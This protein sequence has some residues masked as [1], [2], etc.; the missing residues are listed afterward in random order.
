MGVIEDLRSARQ[1]YERREWVAAYRSL[2][3]LDETDLEAQDFA[4]LATTAYLLGRRNDCIQALQRAHQASLDAGDR[5][6]AVRAAYSL[7]LTLRNVGEVAVSNGWLARATRLL[8]ELT[9]DVVERGYLLDLEMMGHVFSG[10]FAEA[11]PLA[12]RIAEYGRRFGEPD[13]VALGLHAEGR[14]MLYAGRVADGLRR[15]DEALVGVMAGEVTPVTAGRVYCSTIEACQE[16]SD[17]GRAGEWTH[18]LTTWCDVQPGLVA[19]TGQCATHRGQLLRLHG[20]YAD[21]VEELERA[22]ERYLALGGH[23]AQALAHYERGETH[24]LRGDDAEA[25]AAF[26]SAAEHGHPA[27]PGRALL[28]LAH[29]RREAAKG[30]VLR[31][32]AER[33][34]PVQRSQ[35]LAAA[36]E[37]LLADGDTDD[38]AAL[39]QE[40]LGIAETFGCTGLQA[41]GH[42]T[43]AMVAL[44]QDAPAAALEAARRAMEAWAQLSAPYEVARSRVLIGRALRALGD[45]DSAVAEL[46]AARRTFADLGAVPAEKAAAA[47]LGDERAPGG[48]TPREVEVL[49]LVAVGK[50]N[51]AIATQLF[52]SE[53]TVARH[54]SNIFLKLDVGSRTAAAAFAY[55]NHLV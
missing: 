24:R 51:A 32:L 9:D 7:V 12:P 46:T 52:L 30:A 50:S 42:C 48:L 3:D 55:E 19:Y 14:M 1:T 49:R 35:V 6:G 41:A 39:G 21:A 23:P 29:G 40:L 47:L 36:V 43:A 37:I 44:A 2:S 15:M 18:A 54:L 27:Q 5:P 38:A 10:E 16:V 28:W 26:D 45:E 13:L 8:D 31:L 11:M 17:F 34:N 53:K 22:Q 20:A 33:Q 25:E 4:A